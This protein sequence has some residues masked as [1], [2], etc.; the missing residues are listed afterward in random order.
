MKE[1]V[2]K[3]EKKIHEENI[4]CLPTQALHTGQS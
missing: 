4:A 1:C 2:V 3:A